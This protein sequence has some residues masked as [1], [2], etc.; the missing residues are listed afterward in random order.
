MKKFLTT[1]AAVMLCAGLVFANG[2]QQSASGSSASGAPASKSGKQLVI[3]LGLTGIR[4]NTIFL[5][6]LHSYEARCKANGWRLITGDFNNG[7]ADAST[8]LENCLAAHA[9]IV[10]VQN[11]AENA[12]AD[13]LKQLKAQGCVLGSADQPSQIMQYTVMVNNYDLGKVIGNM[14]VDY[15]KT[16]P[17]SKKGAICSFDTMDFMKQR[18]QGMEDAFK[19][20][21][22]TVVFREDANTQDWGMSFAEDL[23][24]AHPDVQVIMIM[25]DTTALSEVQAFQGAGWTYAKH[26]VGLFGS[27]AGAPAIAAIKQNGFFRGTVY[28]DLVKGCNELLDKCLETVK[29]G[30]IAKD[31]VIYFKPVP[32]TIDNTDVVK[33]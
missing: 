1:A 14:A 19:A 21:G 22:G 3:G 25:V 16:H 17:G 27:D 6:I 23:M 8:F 28:L 18:A 24:T 10:V 2:G 9:N 4:S 11:I 30:K 15:I 32:V 29:T 33:N 13:L 31:A 20:G 12:Y 26:P 5:Q 7:A